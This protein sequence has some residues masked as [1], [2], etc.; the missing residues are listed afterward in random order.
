MKEEEEVERKAKEALEDKS[1]VTIE[2]VASDTN[3][4]NYDD[5]RRIKSKRKMADRE[6]DQVDLA[7]YEKPGK[8]EESSSDGDR[9]IDF[10][11]DYGLSR[12][13]QNQKFEAIQIE[14]EDRIKDAEDFFKKE[15]QG[16]NE[17]IQAQIDT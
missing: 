7:L 16:L 4:E 9:K 12:T 3:S 15:L 10:G 5:E 8:R 14:T 17:N 6:H 11:Q 2:S 13:E 1:D